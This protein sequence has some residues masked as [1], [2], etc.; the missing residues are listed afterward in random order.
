MRRASVMNSV[1][2]SRSADRPETL[3][4]RH[5]QDAANDGAAEALLRRSRAVARQLEQC[6][7][8]RE[9]AL[10]VVELIVEAAARRPL[11]LPRRVVPV[12]HRVVLAA[13]ASCPR[14]CARYSA[15]NSRFSTPIDHP[16]TMM[17]CSVKMKMCSSSPNRSRLARSSGP[18][19]RSN[20]RS[21]S[22]SHKGLRSLL[23]PHR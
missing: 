4:Q 6:G 10:P 21:A 9:P 11:L 14:R 7:R 15:L 5:R 17:W 1:V 18:V 8:A 2:P 19:W 3:E 23:A 12:L 13:P 16:S 22:A 20:P